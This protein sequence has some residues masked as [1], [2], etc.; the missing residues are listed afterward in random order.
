MLA[1]FSNIRSVVFTALHAIF[2][3][4]DSVVGRFE[5]TNVTVRVL[6]DVSTHE[7]VAKL[8]SQLDEANKN[9]A[10]VVLLDHFSQDLN[11]TSVHVGDVTRVNDDRV[12]CPTTSLITRVSLGVTDSFDTRKHLFDHFDVGEVKSLFDTDNK[13]AL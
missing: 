3:K 7:Q 11:R 5:Q 6:N 12:K 2:D 1:V 8:L 13:N 4:S 10:L 9:A